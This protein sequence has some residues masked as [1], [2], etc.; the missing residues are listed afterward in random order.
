MSAAADPYFCPV[1]GEIRL[2]QNP[3]FGVCCEHQW[4][5][6]PVPDIRGIHKIAAYLADQKRMH[7]EQQEADIA[8]RKKL[9]KYAI[10][11]LD[12]PNRVS[13]RAAHDRLVVM[14]KM[15][16]EPDTIRADRE[17]N[18]PEGLWGPAPGW[19]CW[20]GRHGECEPLGAD[21]SCTCGCGLG[22]GGHG[23]D[24]NGVKT[25]GCDCGHEGMG[26]TWHAKDCVWRAVRG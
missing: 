22:M 19:R 17:M 24:Q 23:L 11:L 3:A 6:V 9:A 14:L 1:V 13:S 2:P 12:G 7:A 8:F 26:V 10:E 18:D 16:W 20:V 21:E 25:T 4:V 15:P 5:H